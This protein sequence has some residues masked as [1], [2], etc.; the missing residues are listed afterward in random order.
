VGAEDAATSLLDELGRFGQPD[1]TPDGRWLLT[2]LIAADGS[3]RLFS[4]RADGRPGEPRSIP[5]L[6]P[7]PRPAGRDYQ[8]PSVRIQP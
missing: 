4:A 3:V 8:L 6:G 5:L 2:G 7:C 1:L